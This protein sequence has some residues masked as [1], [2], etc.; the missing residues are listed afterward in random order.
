[1]RALVLIKSLS[2]QTSYTTPKNVHNQRLSV[3]YEHKFINKWQLGQ[4]TNINYILPVLTTM[5]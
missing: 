1:M 4:L 3:H 2:I 5:L